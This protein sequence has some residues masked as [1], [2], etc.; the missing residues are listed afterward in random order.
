MH[1]KMSYTQ[2]RAAVHAHIHKEC[3]P[4]GVFSC[5]PLP[6]SSSPVPY[7]SLRSPPRLSSSWHRASTPHRPPCGRFR[8]EFV[9]VK[10]VIEAA[11]P[12]LHAP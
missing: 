10:Q 6:L 11:A 3:L 4:A 5:A 12:W 8:H 7:T 1:C 9:S 2:D